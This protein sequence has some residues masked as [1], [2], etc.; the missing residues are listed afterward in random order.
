MYW[1][2]AKSILNSD[3]IRVARGSKYLRGF[4]RLRG[5]AGGD[6]GAGRMGAPIAEVYSARMP[7]SAS[8]FTSAA[9]I[10]AGGGLVAVQGG[11]GLDDL[12]AAAMAMHV[13]EAADVH[14]DVEAQSGA[15]VK[16]AQGFVVLAAMAQAQL[17]DLRTRG[18]GSAAT[19]SRIW[20]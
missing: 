10:A 8:R 2:S 20:R 6:L 7:A 3:R 14:E 18:S 19:R 13:A 4:T 1:A 12:H 5:V 11:E 16:G 9:E 15:G 17:Y